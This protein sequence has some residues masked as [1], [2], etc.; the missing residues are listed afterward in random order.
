MAASDWLPLATTAL[1]GLLATGGCA[2][3]QW[4]NGTR[5]AR[6]GTPAASATTRTAK[7]SSIWAARARR[8]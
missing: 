4:T 3:V 2:L 5:T 6:N 7:S 8:W 1:G